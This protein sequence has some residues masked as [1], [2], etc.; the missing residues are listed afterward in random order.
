[1]LGTGTE[2]GKT[3]ATAACLYAL[4][5]HPEHPLLH[6]S[7]GASRPI[8]LKPIESGAVPAAADADAL[9]RAST[10]PRSPMPYTLQAPISP[11]LAAEQEGI[12]IDLDRVRSWVDLHTNCLVLVETAGGAFSPVSLRQTNADLARALCPAA[13]VLVAPDR[14]GVLHDVTATV[15]ALRATA[16]GLPAPNVALMPSAED[17]SR[18]RN[19]TELRRLQV[20]RRVVSFPY[21]EPDSAGCVAAAV[22]LLDG[23]AEELEL[24]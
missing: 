9:A 21:A 15:R 11:H 10:A 1:M 16:P 2:I 20:A 23:I 8:G 24:G 4:A 12:E 18:G 5:A 7:A 6:F 13:C 3:H 19:A 14:L 22:K 17:A